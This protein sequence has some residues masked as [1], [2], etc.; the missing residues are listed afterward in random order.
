MLHH[1]M[2]LLEYHKHITALKKKYKMTYD[3]VV[4][5]FIKKI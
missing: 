3:E 4:A 2:S 5:T 1:D